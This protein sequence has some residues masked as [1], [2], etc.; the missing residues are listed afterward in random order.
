MTRL[1]TY[2]TIGRDAVAKVI[3]GFTVINFPIAR[4]E[5]YKAYGE[6]KNKTLWLE[7]S[8]WGERL[9][10]LPLLKKGQLCYVDGQPELK[11][12]KD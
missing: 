5:K 12:F 6:V 9:D 2:G 10:L 11:P 8:I 3:N 4:T 1:I 7:C